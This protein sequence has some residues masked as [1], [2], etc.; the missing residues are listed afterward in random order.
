MHRKEK[1][2]PASNQAADVSEEW[3]TAI[4]AASLKPLIYIF[5]C[6]YICSIYLLYTLFIYM[7]YISNIYIVYIYTYLVKFAMQ[8]GVDFL[9]FQNFLINEIMI[10]FQ[11]KLN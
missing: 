11:E 4:Q 10:Y 6:I 1:Q 7:V 5:T 2:P 3:K 8:L 9:F